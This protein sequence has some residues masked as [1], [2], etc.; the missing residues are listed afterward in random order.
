MWKVA[1]YCSGVATGILVYQYYSKPR[2]CKSKNVDKVKLEDGEICQVLFFPDSAALAVGGNESKK[3]RGHYLYRDILY[4]E[5]MKEEASLATLIRYLESAQ[6]S[7]DLC[8]FVVNSHQLTDAVLGNFDKKNKGRF[9][10]RLVVDE[11]SVV[12]A[13]SAVTKFRSKGAFVRSPGISKKDGYLMH[14]KFAIIDDRILITGSFNWTMQA[15]MGNKENLIIS[16]DQRLVQ[17]F[18]QEFN[19]IWDEFS[20]GNGSGDK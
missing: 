11:G 18:I 4:K 9:R 3:T 10:V 6:V 15:I 1:C 5:C 12:S 14:H 16:N 8:L 19:K 17:P 7:I 13:G 20:P 2:V